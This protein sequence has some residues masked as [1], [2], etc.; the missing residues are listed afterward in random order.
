MLG[1]AVTAEIYSAYPDLLEGQLAKLRASVVN[2]A[3]LADIAL[4]LGLGDR[5][6][7]G[8][9]EELSGGRA[10]ESI[11]ADALEAVIGAVFVDGG[12]EVARS[13]V[14]DLVSENIAKGAEMPGR[15]DFKTQLQEVAA[16]LGLDAP[17]Y[18]LSGSGPDHQRWFCAKAVIDSTTWGEGEGSS[19]KRAEQAAAEAALVALGVTHRA[20]LIEHGFI[21]DDGLAEMT[22]PAD[23]RS[24]KGDTGA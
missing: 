9:G 22:S 2:T 11:L 12:W 3:S 17:S 4:S 14:L 13:V 21:I 15:G 7:L 18:R 6:R 5:L 10:K 19:K 23:Q 24:E 1:L 20:E 8:R 16:R